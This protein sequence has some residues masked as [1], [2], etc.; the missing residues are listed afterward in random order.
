MRQAHTNGF[1][2]G[3]KQYAHEADEN[4]EILGTRRVRLSAASFRT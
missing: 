1:N 4:Q 3:E 2:R